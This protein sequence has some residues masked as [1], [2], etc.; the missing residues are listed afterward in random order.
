MSTYSHKSYLEQQG[1]YK[2]LMGWLTSTDHKRIGLLYM[3]GIVTFFFIAAIL[4]LT[5]RI[6]KFA[7]G[8]D[9]MDAQTYNGVFTLHGIIMIFIVVIPGLA[10]V[11]GN[12]FL[13]IMIGAK[14][15]AFPKLNLL[16]W[17]LWLA[18]SLLEISSD[19]R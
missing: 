12:F 11:F 9:I 10:A 4:G 3:Y 16:S 18:G 1:R 15:V 6:E 5:M 13:P 17:Y 2:G 8:Q 19:M 14:D 7:P